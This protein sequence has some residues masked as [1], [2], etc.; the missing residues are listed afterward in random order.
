[1]AIRVYCIDDHQLIV[2]GLRADLD[3]HHD[4][5]V[6]GTATD[7]HVGLSE[8]MARRDSVDI[9]LTDIEMPGM[10]G[11]AVCD[12]LKR[13]GVLPRVAYLTYHI[14]DDVRHKATRTKMDGMIYKNATVSELV[15]FLHAVH[16]GTSTIIRNLPVDVTI[17]RA[18][19]KLTSTE[20]TVLRLIACEGLTN[21]EAAARLN[22]SK[23][24]VETHRKNIMFKLEVRNTVEL[25]H[26]AIGVGICNE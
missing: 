22:R 2:D 26:Y 20:K 10:T 11:F 16:A 24:T 6:V 13:E 18:S 14:S 12:A 25:V 7:P 17:I 4:I 19:A 1:M 5:S 8:I 23:D 21:A 15:D 9:V 3:G